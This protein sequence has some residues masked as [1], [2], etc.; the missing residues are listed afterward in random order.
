MDPTQAPGTLLCLSHL[1]WKFV[2]QRPQHLLSRA[3]QSYHAVFVEEPVFSD[4]CDPFLDINIDRSGVEVVTP[5]LR[6]RQRPDQLLHR[7][8]A[9][10]PRDK[11]ILWYYTPLALTQTRHL[12]AALV[13]YD[14]MDELSAFR[15]A[16]PELKAAEAE[17]LERADVVF[18]GG[19][20]LYE[21]KRELHPN[22]HL[23]PSSVDTAHFGKARQGHLADPA[24]QASIP[25]PRLGFFGVIDERFD[26]DLLAG[27]ADRRPDWSFIMVGPVVKIDPATLPQRA[28]IFWLG[29]RD[30]QELPRYLAHWDLGIMPFALNEATRFISPT[31][32]PEFLAAGLPVISSAIADVVRP[33]GEQGLVEIAGTAESFVRRA[34]ELLSRPRDEWLTRVNAFLAGLSWDRT[35]DGMHGVMLKALRT[36]GKRAQSVRET[37]VLLPDQEARNAGI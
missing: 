10:L 37:Q 17:L 22:I 31:K 23:F 27:M 33:Y 9:A 13:V 35:W 2:Y 6:P 29:G 18:T 1:R 14:C 30:Y 32:T 20:S 28:N 25:H 3:A 16:P 21:A 19:Q 36:R 8:F 11:L 15:F 7:L 4:D 34:H 26:L 12:D 24:G 5:M